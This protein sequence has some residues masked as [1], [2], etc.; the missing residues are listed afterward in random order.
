MDD[1]PA[2]QKKTTN[3]VSP[4]SHLPS[5]ENMMIRPSLESPGT[6]RPL[7]FDYSDAVELH[8]GPE[9]HVL[10]AFAK[11]LVRDSACFEV[12]LKKEWVEGQTRVIKLPEELPHVVSHYLEYTYSKRLPLELVKEQPADYLQLLAE[13]YVL[14]QR[15]SNHPL[16]T[17]VLREFIRLK[18]SPGTFTEAFTEA[19]NIIYYH[20]AEG[21]PARRLNNDN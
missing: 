11:F 20:T 17:A 15:L 13:L 8:V 6:T 21:C 19:T 5:V 10:L 9:K 2:T 18:M 3:G 16:R 4:R 12:A 7:S 1:N 14:G